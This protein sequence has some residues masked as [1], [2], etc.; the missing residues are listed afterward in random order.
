MGERR[1]RP[2]TLCPCHFRGRAVPRRGAGRVLGPDH[3]RRRPRERVPSSRRCCR[4]WP[5]PSTSCAMRRS[6]VLEL[7]PTATTSDTTIIAAL[8]FETRGPH[9]ELALR[10][11]SARRAKS[12][13]SALIDAALREDEFALHLQPIVSPARRRLSQWQ[14]L[15]VEVLIRLP[16]QEFG[17]LS[18][19]E[20]LDTAE[21]NGRMPAIDRWV[22]RA[23]LVW[24]QRN[25]DRWADAQRGVLG[26]SL[27]QVGG[28]SGLPR[29]PGTLPR[30]VGPAA[31]VAALRS[32]RARL[33]AS[34]RRSSP[35]WRV[36]SSS[37]A[38]KCRWTMPARARAASISCA[39]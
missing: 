12:S 33:P 25:R 22:I 6:Q 26:E 11:R 8:R 13:C 30:Q 14:P 28:A 18:S 32:R 19:H 7:A 1:Y 17:V 31:D 34:R 9:D 15:I 36:R 37:A 27:R 24:M 39:K 5:R 38:A 10:S 4:C 16:T 2:R 21:R 29:L 20:F 23:L 3:L 35:R